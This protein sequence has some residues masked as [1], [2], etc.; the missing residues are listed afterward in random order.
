MFGLGCLGNWR[1]RGLLVG[2]VEGF[3]WGIGV[4]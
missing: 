2:C 3:D 4:C 1:G